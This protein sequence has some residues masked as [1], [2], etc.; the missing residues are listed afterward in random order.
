MLK[1][2]EDL[3]ATGS[4]PHRAPTGGILPTIHSRCQTVSMRP[5]ATD[6][7]TQWLLNRCDITPQQAALLAALSG[8]RP[9]VAL[10]LEA[11]AVI[12]DRDRVASWSI[13]LRRDRLKAVWPIASELEVEKDLDDWLG[14][15]MTWFRDVWHRFLD[16]ELPVTNIDAIE[17]LDEE[18]AGKH[19]LTSISCYPRRTSLSRNGQTSCAPVMLM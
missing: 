6:V 5:V 3:R 17:Q 1:V 4:A 19:G 18:A 2:L 7:I 12:A 11:E 10:D 16:P 9:G 13:A 14:M 15:M 8:G